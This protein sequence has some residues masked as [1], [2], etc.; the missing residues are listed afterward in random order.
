MTKPATLLRNRPLRSSKGQALILL[1]VAFLVLLGFVGL[2]T[3]V[4]ILYIFMGHLR[5]AVDA[6]SLAAAAQYREG[7]SNVELTSAAVQVMNLNG[8]DPNLYT[9]VVE[10]CETAPGDPA[11]CTTPR[12]KLVRVTSDL[13]VPTA[14]LRLLGVDNIRICP[15]G[16]LDRFS[17]ACLGRIISSVQ[18]SRHILANCKNHISVLIRLTV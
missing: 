10:T 15:I 16:Y 11:L 6:A 5:R 2:I 17:P 8:I 14:F 12:R 1:A 18:P 4:G 9:I 3:D 13:G 7:R